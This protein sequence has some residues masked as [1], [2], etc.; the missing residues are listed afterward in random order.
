MEL[1]SPARLS[2]RARGEGCLARFTVKALIRCLVEYCS[3]YLLYLLFI[4]Y[5]DQADCYDIALLHRI[6]S[7]RLE[8][9]TMSPA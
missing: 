2:L 6:V 9:H 1:R 8:Q 5:I 7:W 4:P 3:I